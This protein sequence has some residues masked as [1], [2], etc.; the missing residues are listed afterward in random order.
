[1]GQMKTVRVLGLGNVLGGD[2]ALGP[3]VLKVLDASYDFPPEVCLVEIGTPGLALSS[4]LP[5]GEV[6]ILVDAV[7]GEGQPGEL[8]TYRGEEVLKRISRERIESHEPALE[9]ALFAANLQ[10]G[11]PVDIL[12]IGVVPL[13][14][15]AGIGLSAPVRAAADRAVVAVIGE[16]ARLGI[17]VKPKSVP[18]EPDLWWERAP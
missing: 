10:G 3:F 14:V 7:R 4:F 9:H 8:L 16:L 11:S 2:D 1:M 17:E 15:E 12:L 5:G 18:D 13:R 6:L